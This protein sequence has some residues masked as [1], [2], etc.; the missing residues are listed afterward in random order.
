MQRST[1]KGILGVRDEAS[2][3]QRKRP[4]SICSGQAGRCVEGWCRGRDAGGRGEKKSI[5]ISE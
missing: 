1:W 5:V 3:K 4:L 2:L